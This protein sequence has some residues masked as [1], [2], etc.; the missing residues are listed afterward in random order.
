[1]K[2]ITGHRVLD[3]Y[4]SNAL[5]PVRS[6]RQQGPQGGAREAAPRNEDAARVNISEGARELAKAQMSNPVRIESLQGKVALGPSAFD[7]S[8]VAQ[9]LVGELTG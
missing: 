1:M 3:A 6:V 2:G 4:A 8:V 5:T 9:K 7:T